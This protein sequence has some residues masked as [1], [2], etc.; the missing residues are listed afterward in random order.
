MTVW[1][2]E[3]YPSGE[4]HIICRSTLIL[5][6]RSK[7]VRMVIGLTFGMEGDLP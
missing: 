3:R 2:V 7:S 1:M 5:S 4:D 6:M